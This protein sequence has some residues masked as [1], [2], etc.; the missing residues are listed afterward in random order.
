MM[1][2]ASARSAGSRLPEKTIVADRAC[3][4]EPLGEPL[5]PVLEGGEGEQ[6]AADVLAAQV[7]IDQRADGLRREAQVLDQRAALEPISD[8]ARGRLAKP[9]IHRDLEA[10]LRPARDEGPQLRLQH[11]PHQ[12]LVAERSDL[13]ATRKREPELDQA[14]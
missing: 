13:L 14:S 2:A 7:S 4:A 6:L 8:L 10:A 12:R 3:G 5:R 11:A 1:R 9:P